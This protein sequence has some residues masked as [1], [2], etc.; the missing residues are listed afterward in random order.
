MGIE[1]CDGGNWLRENIIPTYVFMFSI[2]K[3]F[4][5]ACS[6]IERLEFPKN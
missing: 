4:L 5:C 6:Q 1:D 2:R 3:Y